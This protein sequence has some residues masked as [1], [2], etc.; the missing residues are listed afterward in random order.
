MPG[1]QPANLRKCCQFVEG[2]SVYNANT[3]IIKAHL[4]RFLVDTVIFVVTSTEAKDH[5]YATLE[6]QKLKQKRL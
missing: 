3:W 5:G 4:Q 1:P 6:F 2:F